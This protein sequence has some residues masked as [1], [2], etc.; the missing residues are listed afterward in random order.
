VQSVAAAVWAQVAGRGVIFIVLHLC[1]T[2]N[3]VDFYI[4]HTDFSIVVVSPVLYALTV[5]DGSFVSKSSGS[6]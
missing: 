6:K 1:V 2:Y 3:Q 5:H 4:H